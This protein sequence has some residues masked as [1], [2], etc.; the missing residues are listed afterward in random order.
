MET[1]NYIIICA[2]SAFMIGCISMS[3]YVFYT[4]IMTP[5]ENER[6][7]AQIDAYPLSITVPLR[8]YVQGE[9]P[10]AS[11]LRR[12][13]ITVEANKHNHTL[14]ILIDET[15]Y[16]IATDDEVEEDKYNAIPYSIAI[17]M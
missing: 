7:L 15:F 11:S 13:T 8:F 9:I 6:R 14:P 4:Y 10:T 3:G 12:N 5:P 2:L 17:I 16:K 1:I